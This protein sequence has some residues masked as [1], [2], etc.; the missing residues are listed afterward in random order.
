MVEPKT[1][2]PLPA[3]RA[4]MARVADDPA[5]L[6]ASL[7]E[8]LPSSAPWGAR[9]RAWVAAAATEDPVDQAILIRSMAAR[10]GRP[11]SFV[12][13]RLLHH[14][15]AHLARHLAAAMGQP[16]E[17]LVQRILELSSGGPT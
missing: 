14:A 15:V 11:L 2:D 17:A 6:L 4:A 10:G 5:A 1:A 9:H 16:P 12:E 8:P 3:W 13:Q 7:S